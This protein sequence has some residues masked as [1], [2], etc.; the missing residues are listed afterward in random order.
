MLEYELYGE[1]S[2]YIDSFYT[3]E[4]VE[5]YIKE[6][7]AFDKRNNIQEEYYIEKSQEV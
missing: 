6:L 7:Q 1:E 4:E 2:G 3:L 5:E